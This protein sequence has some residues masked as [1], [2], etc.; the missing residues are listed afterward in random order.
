MS[1]YMLHVN[2]RCILSELMLHTKMC[3]AELVLHTKPKNV[4]YPPKL[5]DIRTSVMSKH[6][7]TYAA[8]QY[9]MC[10]IRTNVTCKNDICP[11]Q[12]RELIREMT[13]LVPR[14]YKCVYAASWLGFRDSENV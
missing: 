13:I 5:Y 1:E 6:V 8:H 2:M 10:C 3:N 7:R 11:N 14:G 9:E 12:Y 4:I